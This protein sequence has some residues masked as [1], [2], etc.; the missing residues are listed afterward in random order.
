MVDPL[1]LTLIGAGLGAAGSAFGGGGVMGKKPNVRQVT[2]RSPEQLNVMNQQLAQGSQNADFSGI[3][4]RARTM[5]QTKTVPSLAERFTSMGSGSQ[6]SS[7]FTSA[8]GSAGVDLESQLAALRSQYGMQQLQ[9]GLQPQFENIMEPRIPGMIEGGLSAATS[10][11]PF[12]A[13]G[14]MGGQGGQQQG[15]NVQ[16]Q[17]ASLMK[18]PEGSSF[19]KRLMWQVMQG[20]Q[21]AQQGGTL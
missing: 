21:G 13:M 1:T 19:I 16:Q 9:M 4:N 5:F 10:F 18:T 2:T 12:A 8:L 14:G 3:E 17:M 15:G 20:Q 7:A 6:G 11:L